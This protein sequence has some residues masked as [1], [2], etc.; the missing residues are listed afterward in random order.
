MFGQQTRMM[1]VAGGSILAL[2]GSVA[3]ASADGYARRPVGAACCAFSWTGLYIGVNGGYAWSEDQTVRIDE[4]DVTPATAP[5]TLFSRN[6]FGSLSP[7]GGFAGVQAGANLQLGAIVLGFEADAQWADIDGDS[8]FTLSPYLVAGDF[9]TVTTSNKVSRFGTFRPR[10]GLAWDRTLVYATG[11]LAWGRVEHTMTWRD[12]YGFAAVDHVAGTHVGYAVGG[13]VE[14]AFSP[15]VS[16][17]VEYQ[18]IDLGSEHYAALEYSGGNTSQYVVNTDT[19]TDFHTVRLGLNVKL[20][21][22]EAAPLK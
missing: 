3:T 13:G 6:N 21:G 18:Y 9:A 5:P 17:K 4:F 22:R 15:H 16:L 8:A 12:S 10:V 1:L 2:C 14:H 20:G 19:R 11:G 7:A